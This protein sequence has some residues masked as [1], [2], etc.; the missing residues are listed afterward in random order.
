MERP[1]GKSGVKSWRCLIKLGHHMEKVVRVEAHNVLQAI[2]KARY[3]SGPRAT[4]RL[5]PSGRVEPAGQ[6][7]VAQLKTSAGSCQKMGCVL[8][9]LL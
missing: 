2:Q 7:E 6:I 8:R 5:C 3:F 9:L 1:E 4:W